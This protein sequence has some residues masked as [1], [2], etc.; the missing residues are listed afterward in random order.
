[1]L[2]LPENP[3]ERENYVT[4]LKHAKFLAVGGNSKF[5]FLFSIFYLQ[6]NYEFTATEKERER[7]KNGDCAVNAA[8][9]NPTQF[10]LMEIDTCDCVNALTCR[11]FNSNPASPPVIPSST[12][13]KRG[14]EI[15][16]EPPRSYPRFVPGICSSKGGP[17]PSH[18]GFS[19][20]K[21]LG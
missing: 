20:D 6:Q 1:M 11:A 9:I 8:S 4:L 17:F 13:R 3:H 12:R 2:P 5:L 21:S 14:A 15:F 10:G 16:R 18:S 7:E 19:R